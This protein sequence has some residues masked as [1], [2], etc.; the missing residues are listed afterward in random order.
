MEDSY[1]HQ[2][3]M[4]VI[5]DEMLEMIHLALQYDPIRDLDSI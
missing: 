2:R 5:L 1:E 4:A 3:T